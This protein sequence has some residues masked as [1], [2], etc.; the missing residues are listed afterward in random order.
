MLDELG[1][2]NY[3]TTVRGFLANSAIRASA[4][5]AF[6]ADDIT[7]IDWA[8]SYTSTLK[9]RRRRDRACSC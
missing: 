6:T 5:Y 4:D 1:A 2:M 9:K 3:S 7:G 8:S